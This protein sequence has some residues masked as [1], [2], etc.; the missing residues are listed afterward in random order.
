MGQLQTWHLYAAAGVYGLL[1]MFSLAGI[2]TV[3]PTILPE[4]KLTTANALE[5]LSFGVGGMI[6]PALGGVL[7]GLIG[8]AH[9]ALAHENTIAPALEA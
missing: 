3:F 8:V 7:I 2:P 9:P 4:E 1:K 5:S 6:G